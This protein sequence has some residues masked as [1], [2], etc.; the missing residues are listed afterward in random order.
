MRPDLMTSYPLIALLL[1][2]VMLTSA[3]AAGTPPTLCQDDRFHSA[4]PLVE[5]V[6][7]GWRVFQEAVRQTKSLGE[8]S[9]DACMQTFKNKSVHSTSGTVYFRPPG[10]MRVEVTKGGAKSGS[11]IVKEENGT[12]RAQ[13]GPTLLWMKMTLESDSRLLQLPNGL[14]IL[15]CDLDSLL[16]RLTK[17]RLLVSKT[18]LTVANFSEPVLVLEA[19]ESSGS[20]TTNIVAERVFLDANRRIPLQ[21]EIFHE[22]ALLSSVTFNNMRTAHLEDSQ[23]QL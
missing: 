6:E 15:Q 4:V 19:L 12:I 14:N 17:H 21:W 13:G 11:V 2:L 7:D 9:F 22:G 23:F 20:A 16:S 10:L 1:M 5:S 18:P 8:Y 3:G